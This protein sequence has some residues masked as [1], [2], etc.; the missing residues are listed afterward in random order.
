MIDIDKELV[1][2]C[3]NECGQIAVACSLRMILEN[4][5]F[6]CE[7]CGCEFQGAQHPTWLTSA[8]THQ[9]NNSDRQLFKDMQVL[10][11]YRY[12]D[13]NCPST[14]FLEELLLQYPQY[15]QL[16]P[17]SDNAK[18]NRKRRKKEPIRKAKPQNNGCLPVVFHLFFFFYLLKNI[19]QCIVTGASTRLSP[20]LSNSKATLVYLLFLLFF[21]VSSFKCSVSDNLNIGNG[22]HL[23]KW[24]L[25][26]GV[27]C[28]GIRFMF[29]MM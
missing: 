6:L 12:A 16:F 13:G 14:A 10:F 28:L 27:M 1:V 18:N 4:R 23:M 11:A 5:S 7:A 29:A 19:Y 21:I 8:T 26:W 25:F 9:L 17:G 24:L 3:P 15:R 20:P 22:M 2:T